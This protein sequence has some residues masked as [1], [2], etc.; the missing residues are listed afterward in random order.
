MRILFYTILVTLGLSL[1]IIII[2]PSF[3]DINTYKSKL[4]ELVLKQTGYNLIIKGPMEIS[5]F[6]R[7]KLNAEE[8]TLNNKNEP[9]FKAKKL[10]I[11]PSIL[12]FLKGNLNFESISINKALLFIKKNKSNE[13]N[14]SLSKLEKKNE[15]NISEK[16]KTLQKKQQENFFIIKNLLLENSTIYYSE[17]DRKETIENIN[18]NLKE[19]RNKELS[20]KGQFTVK[21]HKNKVN[22]EASILNK[23]AI[24]FS[25]AI[26]SDF[27]NLDTL[28]IYNYKE[29]SG[30]FELVGNIKTK[31][32]LKHIKELRSDNLKINT[33]INLN[34]KNL[35]L[36]NLKIIS[37][38]TEFE[39]HANLNF[40]KKQ[41][42]ISIK[43]FSDKIDINDFYTKAQPLSKD[44]N[45]KNNNKENK[46]N[47]NSKDSKKINNNIFGPLE[48][49][50]LNAEIVANQIKYKNIYL[51]KVVMQLIKKKNINVNINAENFFN[52]LLKTKFILNKKLDFFADI[53]LKNLSL[54]DLNKLY[55]VNLIS[56]KINLVSNL[57]GNMIKKEKIYNTITGTT[58]ITSEE[59]VIN[60]LNLNS[61]KTDIVKLKNL[62][63]LNE[64]RKSLFNGD[65]NIQDQKIK[66]IHDKGVIKVPLTKIKA[67]K[68]YITTSGE[69]N[70]NENKINLTSNYNDNNSL[71]SLFSLNTTGKANNPLT[72]LSFNEGAVTKILEKITKKQMKKVLEKKLEDKFDNIIDNLL[73]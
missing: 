3:F 58:S 36:D 12:S 64:I 40:L 17:P 27:Y 4:Y 38:N 62:E 22:Y 33:K 47:G 49:Y 45:L 6:P 66:L 70:I 8:I 39:G 43:L 63:D 48:D 10:T 23:N 21:G 29:N 46:K 15:K 61:L 5:I 71:L 31:K 52:S 67:G 9:L 28:G 37:Q 56:G 50:N 55:N 20:L 26:G 68:D 41:K 24:K 11:F 72:K 59:L 42:K 53:N 14:W 65:T 35:S 54:Q 51:E 1:S 19:V 44:N 57:Q 69:Y 2:A 25:G 7:L 32:I 16:N 13:Y 18:L 73:Q 30:S 60:N 34:K